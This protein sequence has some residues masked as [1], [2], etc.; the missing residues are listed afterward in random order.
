MTMIPGVVSHP[1]R[2]RETSRGSGGDRD[3]L[4][5]IVCQ[6]EQTTRFKINKLIIQIV[7]KFEK[8]DRKNNPFSHP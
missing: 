6:G 1:L 5:K 3:E 8:C 4:D 7:L 2:E